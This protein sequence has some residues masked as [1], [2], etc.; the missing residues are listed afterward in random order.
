MGKEEINISIYADYLIVHVSNSKNST[1][2]HLQV[3]N[4]FS[5]VVGHK[6]N[7]NKPLYK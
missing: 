3:I 6:I 1:R 5:K 7:S 2:E 4:N